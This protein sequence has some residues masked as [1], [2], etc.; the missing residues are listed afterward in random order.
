[1]SKME[2]NQMND[3]ELEN[4]SGGK[5]IGK[6]SSLVF[7]ESENGGK[8]KASSAVMSGQKPKAI[9]LVA[10]DKK[11]IDNKLMSGDFANKGNYC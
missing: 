1:M 5:N 7:N 4:V 3:N 11:D 6:A 2:L 9:K 10:S 8:P